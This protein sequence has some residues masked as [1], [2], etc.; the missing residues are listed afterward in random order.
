MGGV[1]PAPLINY[2]SGSVTV[3]AQVS[4]NVPHVAVIV[5]VPAALAVTTPLLSTLAYVLASDD[6][7][8]EPVAP[9]GASTAVKRA[10][11]PSTSEST[12]G[13]T[14]IPVGSGVVLML[15]GV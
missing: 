7:V 13:I 6:Q 5:A 10:L 3:T 4:V 11:A 15:S 12:L 2:G 14:P 8:I 1:S 9:S